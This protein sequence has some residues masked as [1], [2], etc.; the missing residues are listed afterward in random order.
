MHYL[1]F[2]LNLTR[3]YVSKRIDDPRV[4][5]IVAADVKIKHLGDTVAPVLSGHPWDN[6]KLAA[7]DRW[8]LIPGFK[9]M[10]KKNIEYFHFGSI[11]QIY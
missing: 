9:I 10:E 6:A 7:K 11:A 3:L 4:S 2:Y 5:S 8:P 1:T